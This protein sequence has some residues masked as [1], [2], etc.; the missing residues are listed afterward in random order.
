M[1]SEIPM[2]VSSGRAAIYAPS[3]RPSVT[4]L[5]LY[6]SLILAMRYKSVFLCVL[7]MPIKK[8]KSSLSTQ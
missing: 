6:L 5:T 2:P 7:M 3:I 4:V 8:I 1:G